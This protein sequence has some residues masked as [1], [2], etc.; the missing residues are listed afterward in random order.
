MKIYLSAI[1][2]NFIIPTRY[3][4]LSKY[5]RIDDLEKLL[6]FLL[7]D[8]Y[9]LQSFFKVTNTQ[10]Y[11]MIFSKC[12]DVII[13]S[14]AVAFMTANYK[15]KNKQNFDVRG[16][17]RKYGEFIKKQNIEKFIELDIEGVFGYQIYCDCLKILQDVSGKDPIRV[18][19][20]WRNLDYFLELVKVKS[21]IALGDVDILT[22]NQSQEEYFLDMI[23][24]AH[25]NNCEVHGLA[26]T[27]FNKLSH[28]PFDSVDSIS[29][30]SGARFA[31]FARFDG[32][33]INYYD[34]SNRDKNIVLYHL[35][36]M[37]QGFDEWKKLAKYYDRNY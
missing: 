27:N 37:K 36:L 6:N 31:N 15:N 28:L 21:Y 19:H 12:K 17:A 16:Y 33:R 22:R 34:A 5:Y 7:N 20:R 30:K 35:L 2:D 29:W 14:G 26:F 18:F 9:L 10:D 25:K 8:V 32:R 4:E 13:D 11:E 24:L 3:K 23:T 1:L